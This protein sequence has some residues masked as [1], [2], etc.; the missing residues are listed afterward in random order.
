MVSAVFHDPSGTGVAGT[1]PAVSVSKPAAAT[2]TP[3]A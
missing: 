1:P 3:S 2:P